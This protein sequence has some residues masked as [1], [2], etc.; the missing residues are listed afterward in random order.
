MQDP[1]PIVLMLADRIKK[2]RT[3]WRDTKALILLVARTGDWNGAA[4]LCDAFGLDDLA[5]ERMYREAYGYSQPPW[6]DHRPGV[7]PQPFGR[8]P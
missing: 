5:A 3:G 1:L 7:P 2:S 4:A 6:S 8:K